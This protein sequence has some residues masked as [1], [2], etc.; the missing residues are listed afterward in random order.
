MEKDTYLPVSHHIRMIIL[1]QNCDFYL[2]TI[3]R[4]RPPKDTKQR[5]IRTIC[6]TSLLYQKLG[7]GF[8]TSTAFSL[9]VT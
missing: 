4:I 3:S 2:A 8:L 9:D 6:T 7:N 1:E 5:S